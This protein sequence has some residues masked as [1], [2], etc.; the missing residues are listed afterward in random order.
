MRNI[1]IVALIL[2]TFSNPAFASAKCYGRFINPITHVD[3]SALFPLYIAGVKVAS[4][5]NDN[6]TVA[7]RRE[8]ICKCNDR[9]PFVYGVP[10]AFWQPFRAVDVTRK[11][12][13]MVNLGGMQLP[14]GMKAL[15][16]AI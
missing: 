1:L 13:C 16:M 6:S 4:S 7:P 8:A 11:L 15:L 9:H 5:G 3:W 12:Y 10:V 14:I 2:S